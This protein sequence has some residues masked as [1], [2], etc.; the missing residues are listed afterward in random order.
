M[1][2]DRHE[3]VDGIYFYLDRR[4]SADLVTPL[5]RRM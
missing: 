3:A 1:R 4:L 5:V 2:E